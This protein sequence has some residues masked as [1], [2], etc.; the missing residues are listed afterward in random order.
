MSTV[1]RHL[2]A[3]LIG[4]VLAGIG[5][6]LFAPNLFWGLLVGGAMTGGAISVARVLIGKDE[7]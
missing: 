4:A 7:S 1:R 6:V 5:S 2:T 3:A